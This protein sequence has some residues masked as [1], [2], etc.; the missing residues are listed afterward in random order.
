[1]NDSSSEKLLAAEA[2]PLVT[3]ALAALK[4]YDAGSSRAALCALDDAV[5]DALPDPSASAK[6]EASLLAV[7]QQKPS[8]AAVEYI[9]SKLALAGSDACV[10]TLAALLGDP[11]C[12]TPVRNALEK[13][14]G[15][16][17][18]A[19]LRRSLATLKGAERAGA[20]R[21]LG[22][23][24]DADSVDAL[25]GILEE[26]EGQIAA[27]AAYALG[28]IG[29]V[30]ACRVL[31]QCLTK[32]AEAMRPFTT[33]AALVCAERLLAA[34]HK[35][36]ARSLYESLLK[37]TQVPHVR[38]AASLGLERCAAARNQISGT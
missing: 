10:P 17:A 12:S 21:S 36:E 31:K 3:D 16:A 26:S 8:P 5:R 29:S 35:S 6:I 22:A 37:S 11:A 2:S 25:T 7:L 4:T 18:S 30:K 24:A 19:A 38:Q 27:A 9:C 20:I 34:G 13:V 32:G 28:E 15:T 1:M 33:D 23:R 14:P